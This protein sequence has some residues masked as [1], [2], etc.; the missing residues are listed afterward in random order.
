[1]TVATTPELTL[2]SCPCCGLKPL[3][4]AI[5]PLLHVLNAHG[6]PTDDS[7][8]GHRGKPRERYAYVAFDADDATLHGFMATMRVLDT[9]LQFTLAVDWNK[10]FDKACKVLHLC[11]QITDACGRAP[12]P[13]DL[14]AL[15]EELAVVLAARAAA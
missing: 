14:A 11:L 4:E 3:D 8:C 15:A 7:C 5:K 12:K 1:V 9:G 13:A 10:R 6:L 2:I